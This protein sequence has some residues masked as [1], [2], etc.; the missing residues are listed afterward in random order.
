MPED[1]VDDYYSKETYLTCYGHNVSLI[2]GQYMWLK[3]DM[4]EMLPPSYKRRLGNPKKLRSREPDE[5][6]NKGRTQTSY[7]C[8]RCGIHGH[9]A[10]SCTSQVVDPETQKMKRKP[11]K[12]TTGNTTQPSSNATQE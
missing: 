5:D 12:T 2:N 8:T 9:N 1:Y 6:P 4:E 10:R 11:K 3:V 7:C